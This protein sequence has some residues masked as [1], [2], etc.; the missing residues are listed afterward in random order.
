[1]GPSRRDLLRTTGLATTVGLA[2][3]VGASLLDGGSEPPGYLDWLASPGR[4]VDPGEYRVGIVRP[5]ATPNAR[6]RLAPFLPEIP[7]PSIDPLQSERLIVS[8]GVT[9]LTTDVERSAV[10]NAYQDAG[11]RYQRG[12]GEFWILDDGDSDTPVIAAG[13]ETLLVARPTARESAVGVVETLLHAYDTDDHWIQ[14]D[15]GLQSFTEA[16]GTPSALVISLVSWEQTVPQRGQFAGVR[17]YAISHDFTQ[18]QRSYTLLFADPGAVPT[19]AVSSW[20]DSAVADVEEPRLEAEGSIVTVSGR[21]TD[22][23]RVRTT[24]PA[25][26]R[27]WSG[28]GAD[29]RQTASLPDGNPPRGP[30]R[31]RWLFV[32]EDGLDSRDSVE[33]N[34]PRDTPLFH[35]GAMLFNPPAVD[36]GTLFVIGEDCYALDTRDGRLQWEAGLESAGGTPVLDGQRVYCTAEV[37]AAQAVVA[38]NVASGTR[39]WDWHPPVGPVS[40]LVSNGEYLLVGT[41]DHDLSEA[42]QK[43][44]PADGPYG[45][46]ALSDGTEV[47]RATG[48]KVDSMAAVGET[49]VTAGGQAGAIVTA[50]DSTDGTRL[51][52]RELESP[53][54]PTV[55]IG[56]GLVIVT[57]RGGIVGLSLSDGSMQWRVDPERTTS[58]TRPAL[59]DGMAYVGSARPSSEIRPDES[60]G[61]MRA[62]DLEDGTELFRI[63]QTR[64]VTA[65]PVVAGDAVFG[66]SG[67]GAVAR[68]DRDLT[69]TWTLYTSGRLGAPV[70]SGGSIYLPTDLGP[71]AALGTDWLPG[72][73]S[74]LIATRRSRDDDQF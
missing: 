8:Q 7:V 52:Q 24:L 41:S 34:S 58:F 17:A 48:N 63:E 65:R 5:A 31:E 25:A 27:L 21:P 35:V 53:I 13:T 33:D 51:W 22:T 60:G 40:T 72:P 44:P 59:V 54:L 14:S 46:F 26:D 66:V 74:R 2:G 29:S 38:L 70:V 12:I 68:F 11:Y 56:D 57:G 50:R 64:R 39:T 37:D 23:E 15:P 32:P 71:L 47:W 43:P 19:A 9:V 10:V 62:L 4:L 28:L 49:V 6:T 69:R 1:M 16:L 36:D 20:I 42:I 55:S 3:C 45:I 73:T 18:P 61:T 30:V 67:G